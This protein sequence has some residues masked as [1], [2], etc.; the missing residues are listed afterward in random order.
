MKGDN[1][2]SLLR[3]WQLILI[4][5]SRLCQSLCDVKQ[6]AQLELYA[7]LAIK[8]LIANFCEMVH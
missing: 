8:F 5:L 7:A 3:L 4:F 6:E 2:K 1:K